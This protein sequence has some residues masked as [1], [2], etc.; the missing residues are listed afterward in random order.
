MIVVENYGYY[1]DQ[2][3]HVEAKKNCGRPFWKRKLY[4]TV[5][6][7]HGHFIILDFFGAYTQYK[8]KIKSLVLIVIRCHAY[9]HA[10]TRK[11]DYP[12]TFS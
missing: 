9:F 11:W 8:L 3:T 7:I 4:I 2:Q 10:I 6:K 1:K 12:N 5:S